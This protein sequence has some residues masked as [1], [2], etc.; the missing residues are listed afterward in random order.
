MNSIMNDAI[1]NHLAKEKTMAKSGGYGLWAFLDENEKFVGLGISSDRL[2]P[3][4][5]AD[6]THPPVPE[7]AT[8][9]ALIASWSG[10][11]ILPV[12]GDNVRDNPV[13]QLLHRVHDTAEH[14]V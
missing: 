12:P 7:G 3:G 11:N 2:N 6:Y 14:E 4:N 9:M 5:A 10:R 8:H 1:L 13:A